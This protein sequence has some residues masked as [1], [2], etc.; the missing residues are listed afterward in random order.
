MKIL[1]ISD[2]HGKTHALENIILPAHATEVD[3]VIHLG[4]FVRDLFKFQ[5]QYPNLKM[6]G[7]GGSFEPDNGIKFLD[8]CGKKIYYV[9]GHDHEVKSHTS[10][11]EFSAKIR[12]V[13]ACFFGHSHKPVIFTKKNIFFMNPGSVS[14]G[15][16]NPIGYGIVTISDD[17]EFSG[18]LIKL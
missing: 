9:H 12:E 6:L 1:L 17:G 14:E 16:G 2:T 3:F 10:H 7:V 15:R 11:L 8:V 13:D 5:P 18:E 4:D